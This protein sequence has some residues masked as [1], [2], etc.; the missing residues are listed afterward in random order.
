MLVFRKGQWKTVQLPAIDPMFSL[1]HKQRLAAAISGGTFEKAEIEI[2]K[3]IF[4]EIKYP[5]A[6]A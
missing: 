5:K 3:E 4:S 2:Y 6:R 1:V